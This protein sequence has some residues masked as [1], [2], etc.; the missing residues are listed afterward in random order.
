MSIKAT[1]M[2]AATGQQIQTHM[3]G[4]MPYIGT[5]FHL[6]DGERVTAQRVDVGKPAPGKF[7]TPVNVWVT[8]KSGPGSAQPPRD[9]ALPEPAA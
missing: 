1:I 2:N 7:V 6:Q 8:P 5:A 3:F 9:F 4:R